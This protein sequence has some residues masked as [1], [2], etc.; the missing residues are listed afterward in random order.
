MLITILFYTGYSNTISL[1]YHKQIILNTD[2]ESINTNDS[3]NTLIHLD[4]V[5][6]IQRVI[7]LDSLYK[8]N[9]SYAADSILSIV[10]II[11]EYYP[12]NNKLKSY[13]FHIA[14]K[15][16]I[17]RSDI[18][19]GLDLLNKCLEAKMILYGENSTELAK[20]YN[21][22][23]IAY[24]KS[25]DYNNAII[26]YNLSLK[27]LRINNINDLNLFDVHLNLG[28][29]N[30]VLSNY[31][32]AY[33]YFKYAKNILI[34]NN[35]VQLPEEEAKFYTNY[36]NLSTHMGK[37]DE[38]NLFFDK[39]DSILSKIGGVEN[40]KRARLFLNKGIN[41]YHNLDFA[42]ALLFNKKAIE[43]YLESGKYSNSD[44]ARCY[45]N[46]SAVSIKLDNYRESED[47]C[48][49]GLM[50]L[51][52][53]FLRIK[54]LQ[55]LAKSYMYLGE[56]SLAMEYFSEMINLLEESPH[57]LDNFKCQAY[58]S[59]ANFLSTIKDKNSY[60]Y[61]IE[62]LNIIESID[63]INQGEKAYILSRLGWYY[64][65]LENDSK[66]AVEY[67]TNSISIWGKHYDNKSEAIVGRSNDIRFIEAYLGLSSALE[68]L[69]L[70]TDSI[71]YLINSESI[72]SEVTSLIEKV[73]RSISEDN[74]LLLNKKTEEIFDKAISLSFQLYSKTGD[75]KYIKSGFNYAERSR[76]SVLLGSIRGKYALRFSGIPDSQI[77]YERELM[78]EIDATEKLIFDENQKRDPSHKNLSF[79]ESRLL[80]LNIRSDSL[81][82]NLEISYPKYYS[83]KYSNFIQ[84]INSISNKLN[85]NEVILEYE[86]TDSELLIFT[87]EKSSLSFSKS[88]IDSLF[89]CAID[90]LLQIKSADVSVQKHSDYLSFCRNSNL[91]YNYLIGNLNMNLSNK[92]LI[93]IPDGILGYIPFEV[94]LTD[95]VIS[96]RINYSALNYLIKNNSIS[97]CYSAT[98]R[99]NEFNSVDNQNI[100]SDFIGFAPDYEKD[101][102]SYNLESEG[103]FNDLK[104]TIK[105]VKQ[106]GKML[107]GKVYSGKNASKVNFIEK[108]PEFGIIHLAQHAVL[109]DSLPMFSRLVF[110]N[111][112]ITNIDNSL[113][114]YEIFGLEL[115]AQMITLSAC[116]TG[117]G[118]IYNG[119]GIMSLARGFVYSGVPSISMTLWEAAD[120][121]SSE[122]MIS[123]YKYLN[124]GY[125]KDKALQMSKLD[126]L[127]TS[128]YK[129]SHPFFWSSFIVTGNTDALVIDNNKNNWIIA[130]ITVLIG[131]NLL[132]SI[133]IRNRIKKSKCCD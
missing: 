88:M 126:Y 17:D 29:V 102:Y 96:E 68:N 51:P 59:F 87:I 85:A 20:T 69:F 125:T 100:N 36:G 43:I 49:K 86:L 26:N 50:Y 6:I 83:L 78:N 101:E 2:S 41:A 15:I 18:S 14:G 130:L 39:A 30:A 13:V 22:I 19:N 74:L 94:L 1:K 28:I 95:T 56:N 97:Y 42:N 89:T 5:S 92:K 35:I 116:G 108:S 63:N 123:F 127:S 98:L 120:K 57:E 31:T 64:K 67:F 72:L 110:A 114:T 32:D 107:G 124:E 44:I 122:I 99:Y 109:N 8:N 27:I 25:R 53:V 82:K 34:D 73:S 129:Y 21:Y 133:I 66:K 52:D 84:D 112:E 104:Y 93:I 103:I 4:T 23:G 45:N 90:T 71:V 48:L 79:F 24:Y 75:D 128:N 46:L 80:E 60:N 3:S 61:Y 113:Y 76:S 62:S 118:K 117:S 10:G 9:N 105:E 33:E 58:I 132:A 12:N 91:L 81:I 7:I 55:N 115:N 11:K 54:L 70:E 47:Y 77:L 119:E 106:I 16:L 65:E 37:L 131:L 40:Y 121:N 38:S 111:N